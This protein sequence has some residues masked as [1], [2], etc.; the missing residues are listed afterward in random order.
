MGECLVGPRLISRMEE[1]DK[2]N[3]HSSALSVISEVCADG[4]F[5]PDKM[6][7]VTNQIGGSGQLFFMLCLWIHFLLKYHEAGVK[8]YWDQVH[9]ADI[10]VQRT[11]TDVATT[12]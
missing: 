7:E 5:D 2:E 3:I 9:K 6:S 12:E 4:E 10:Q 8:R 11:E 1:F